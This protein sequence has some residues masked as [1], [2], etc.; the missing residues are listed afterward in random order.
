[1]ICTECGKPYPCVH[2]GPPAAIK[3]SPILQEAGA[4][5]IV[6]D[7]QATSA[8]M[9]VALPVRPPSLDDLA[10]QVRAHSDQRNW[11]EEVALRVTRHR[12]RR[13]GGDSASLELDF[14]EGALAVTSSSLIHRRAAITSA[15]QAAIPNTNEPLADT[16]R[17]GTRSELPVQSDT[18]HFSNP[19]R[20]RP[21]KV[22][23]FPRYA[24]DVER[25]APLIT[26][27]ELAEPAP[28]APRIMEAP[29]AQQMELLPSFADI[30]LDETPREDSQSGE[31][32]LPLRPAPPAH[33]LVS[34]LLD[35]GIVAAALVVFVFSFSKIASASLPFRAGLLV[36]AAVGT[37]FW[38]IFQYV[39]LVY[40]TSTPGM[41]A[42]QLELFTFDGSRASRQA[43]R[44]RALASALSALSVGLG[45]A[46]AM[47]DE[48]T[49]GWHDRISRTY[50]KPVARAI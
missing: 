18:G 6:E 21:H 9:S 44:S 31:L 43:R 38:L 35:A 22:I 7:A 39:F 20:L 34:G 15:A 13:R 40:G 3:R 41:R 24:V 5:A 19:A 14:P 50:L 12:A 32:E 30:Q 27:I 16:A 29:A 11:R 26:E 1:M 42:A 49:L 4:R 45:F 28:V 8:D 10:A 33:R 36:L 48:D 25:P 37:I 23:R 2:N 47:V 17:M 46:W